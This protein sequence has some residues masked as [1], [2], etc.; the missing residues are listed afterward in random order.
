MQP[1]I[2]KGFPESSAQSFGSA[3]G[4]IQCEG[5]ERGHRR[6]AEV[7]V[8]G[9]LNPQFNGANLRRGPDWWRPPIMNGWDPRQRF[10][11]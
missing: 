5:I 6:I 3:R 8:S 1:Q 7:A 2:H 4:P 11:Y 10:M 9:S